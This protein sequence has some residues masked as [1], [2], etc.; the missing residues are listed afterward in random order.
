MTLGVRDLKA[1]E[2]AA[3][4]LDGDVRTAPL[5]LADL[6]WIDEFAAGW[7]GPLDALVNNA[8]V[9]DSPEEPTRR[10]AGSFSSRPTT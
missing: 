8:G 4:E 2:R 9:M 5:D 6:D 7:Q 3:A 10:T 1:G